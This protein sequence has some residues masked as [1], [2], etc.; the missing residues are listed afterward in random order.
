MVAI[1]FLLEVFVI[2]VVLLVQL[3]L[4]IVSHKVLVETITLLLLKLLKVVRSLI[5]DVFDSFD[6]V[7]GEVIHLILQI[8]NK[9]IVVSN[10]V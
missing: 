8:I 3:L 9:H 2:P 5:Y 7:F 4:V 10:L 6:L 1:L